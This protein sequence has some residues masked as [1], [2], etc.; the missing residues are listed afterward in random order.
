MI[1]L[2]VSSYCMNC[3]SFK[4]EANQTIMYSGER[5]VICNTYIYCKNKSLCNNIKCHL[6]EKEKTK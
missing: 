3:P 2:R 4:V 5:P 1:E 6:L